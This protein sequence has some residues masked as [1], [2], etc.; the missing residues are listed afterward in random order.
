MFSSLRALFALT[1]GGALLATT[2]GACAGADGSDDAASSSEAVHSKGK[3]GSK[4]TGGSA[5]AGGTDPAAIIA[6][7]QT[8]DGQAIPQPPG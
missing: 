2:L 7:A 8:P 6:A 4:G 5:G 3:G 1:A